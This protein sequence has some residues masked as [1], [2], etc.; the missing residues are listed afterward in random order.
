[1]LNIKEHL[2]DYR[3]TLE[4]DLVICDR[5]TIDEA[6]SRIAELEAENERLTERIHWVH[7]TLYEI[8]PSNYDHDEVCR[9]NVAS[10]EV[11]LGLA[12]SLGETHGKSK[13]W[14]S[15]CAEALSRTGAV[16]AIG[17]IDTLIESLSE[18]LMTDAGLTKADRVAMEH[19]I[20]ALEIAKD[21]I[22]ALVPAAPEDGTRRMSDGEG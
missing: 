9:L 16:K 14:W 15:T 5:R 11:I 18:G 17:V 3:L 19:Q 13:E 10:V 21:G 4:P 20:T 1:M 2:A 7:N 6:A 8:N 22:A 12:P